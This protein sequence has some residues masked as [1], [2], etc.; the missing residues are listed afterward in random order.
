MTFVKPLLLQ[1]NLQSIFFLLSVV[2]D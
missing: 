2:M 1:D